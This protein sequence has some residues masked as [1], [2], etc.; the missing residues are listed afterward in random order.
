[1]IYLHLMAKKGIDTGALVRHFG[2]LLHKISHTPHLSQ[3]HGLLDD[4]MP[5]TICDRPN[6]NEHLRRLTF[7]GAITMV[8]ADYNSPTLIADI[9]EQYEWIVG[10]ND[11]KLVIL[12]IYKSEAAESNAN[13]IIPEIMQSIDNPPLSGIY[14]IDPETGKNAKTILEE[15][16]RLQRQFNAIC[17][18]KAKPSWDYEEVKTEI[19]LEIVDQMKKLNSFWT[20]KKP[21][22][23]RI[24]QLSA[25]QHSLKYYPKLTMFEHAEKLNKEFKLSTTASN[26]FEKYCKRKYEVLTQ[27]KLNERRNTFFERARSNRSLYFSLLPADVYAIFKEIDKQTRHIPK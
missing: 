24:K 1:M 14:T 6:E 9:K 19:E 2:M 16:F 18:E 7:G 13:E 23:D 12:V 27:E 20:S 5:V 15:A 25:L 8:V 3:T 22:Q 21:T 4:G 11:F 17:A 26:P 10:K